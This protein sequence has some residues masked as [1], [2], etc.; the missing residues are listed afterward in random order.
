MRHTITR[1][2]LIFCFVFYLL[3]LLIL[4]MVNCLFKCCICFVSAPILPPHP[5]PKKSYPTFLKFFL[6]LTSLKNLSFRNPIQDFK[7]YFLNFF[8]NLDSFNFLE[9]LL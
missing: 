1:I 9:N 3:I 4:K 2:L 8:K 7:N 6:N 5:H